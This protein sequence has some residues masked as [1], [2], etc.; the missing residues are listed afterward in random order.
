VCAFQDAGISGAVSLR[1]MA[2]LSLLSIPMAAEIVVVEALFIGHIVFLIETLGFG[3]G[4]VAFAAIWAA[5]GLAVLAVIDVLWPRLGGSINVLRSRF[6]RRFAEL[7]DRIPVKALLAVLAV[8]SVVAGA[9]LA[10]GGIADWIADHRGDMVVFIIAAGVISLGLI[11][12]ARLGRVLE[13]WV[14]RVADTAGPLLRSVAALLS[15]ILLGPAMAWLLFRLLRF[16]RRSVYAL[17]LVAAPV[18][19]AVWFPF[20]GLGV[21]G[22]AEGLF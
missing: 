19:A 10:G 16:S 8:A 5:L 3:W 14:R 20:Y 7:R 6:S 21:W 17:T 4:L 2:T 9:A 18:F 13:S 11:I 1:R 12:I 22:L 15:M